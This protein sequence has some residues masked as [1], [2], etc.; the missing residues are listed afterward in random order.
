M[1]VDR[2]AVEFGD[3]LDRF[4]ALLVGWFGE[5]TLRKRGLVLV[6]RSAVHPD[7]G[8]QDLDDGRLV[9]VPG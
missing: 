5:S 2:R 1:D 3:V 8:A 4:L 6:E 7:E 9:S